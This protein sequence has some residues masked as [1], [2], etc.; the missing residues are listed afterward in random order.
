M[1]IAFYWEYSETYD[2]NDR[3][4][5]EIDN[6]LITKRYKKDNEI[7]HYIPYFNYYDWKPIDTVDKYILETNKI[8]NYFGCGYWKIK[9]FYLGTVV[10]ERLLVSVEY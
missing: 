4:S 2:V 5:S 8:Q 7:N 6:E 1:R 3:P 10:W 9:G